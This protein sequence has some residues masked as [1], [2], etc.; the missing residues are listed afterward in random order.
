MT[1]CPTPCSRSCP[2]SRPSSLGPM[3]FAYSYA[4][5]NTFHILLLSPSRCHVEGRGSASHCDW[6]VGL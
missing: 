2:W 5:F 1:C 6:A 4:K 3:S